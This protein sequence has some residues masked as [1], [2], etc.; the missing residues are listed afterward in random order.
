MNLELARKSLEELE[1]EEWALVLASIGTRRRERPIDPV[2][3]AE[4]FERTPWTNDE[5]AKRLSVTSRT[6]VMFK[7]LLRLPQNI[8]ALLQIGKIGI[9][10]GDRLSTLKKDTFSQQFLAKAITDRAIGADLVKSA[11]R[12]KN[13]N[14]DLPIGSCIDMALKAK[15][16][17]EKRHI[18]VTSIEKGVSEALIERAEQA[19]ISLPN[20]LRKVLERNLPNNESLVSI[21]THGA[22][23]LLTLTSEGW[24]ALRQK[25]ASLGVPLDELVET[26][27]KLWLEG[28]A[29]Q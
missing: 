9:D 17:I 3:L 5:I 21:V 18:L 11:V 13:R 7:H 19:Q 1:P 16:T 22:V 26:L 24:E 8:R 27:A 2:T 28:G 14:P 23:I 12:F 15:P 6:V 20:L 29:L 25:S 10:E 4:M